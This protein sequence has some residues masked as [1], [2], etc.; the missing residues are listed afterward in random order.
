MA[1]I[2]AE[3]ILRLA[4]QLGLTTA[5]ISRPA[6][7][8]ETAGQCNRCGACCRGQNGII[9]TL[10]DIYRMAGKLGITPKHF[11]RQYC[12]ISASLYD[13]FGA[14]PQ[15]GILL[16]TKNGI[17]PFHK[18]AIGCSINDAKPLTCRLYPFND[19]TGARISIMKMQRAKDG[20]AFK[21]CYIFNLPNNTIIVPDFTAMAVHHLQRY[22]TRE[23][24]AQAGDRWQPGLAE[25]ANDECI[26]L[27][28]D[29]AQTGQYVKMMQS[30]FEELDR[31]NAVILSDVLKG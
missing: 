4:G 22:V 13:V 11:F 23:Y 26:R 19:F 18:S 5:D 14:G 27:S 30:A 28:T 9:L 12:R 21:G 2:S 25:K 6:Y 20:E 8:S 3:D 10:A 1:H 15:K 24:L 7:V 16:T 29:T 17:C 31:R